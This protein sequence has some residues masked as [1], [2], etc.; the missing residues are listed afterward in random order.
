[1]RKKSRIQSIVY[2]VMVAVCLSGC[3]QTVV[4]EEPVIKVDISEEEADYRMEE[5]T[6]GD[7]ILTKNIS[8]NYVQTKAQEIAFTK[9]GQIID[10]VYVK[11]GDKVAVGDL[12]VELQNGNLEDEI[13]DLEYAIRRT[14]LQYGYLDVYEKFDLDSAYYTFVSST[15]MEEEDLEEYEKEKIEIQDGYKERREDFEDTLY[16]DRLKL[17]QKKAELSSNRI[18]ATMDGT[19]ISMEKDLEGST[20]KRDQVI[21]LVVDNSNGLFET[22]DEE[23]AAFIEEDTVLPMVIVYGTA[24]G[25]YEVVPYKKETWGEKQ[26]F[27]AISEPEGATLEVGTA[28]TITAVVDQKENVLCISKQALY[29]ADGKYYVYMPDEAGLKQVRFIE[30]GLI[31]DTYVEVV[32]GITEGEKVIRK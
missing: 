24:K 10:K 3:G 16:F 18:Y 11:E 15:D 17:E 25:D 27:Q 5:V 2:M 12:L 1:M 9:G 8:S 29:Q 31:G 28:G 6:R 7:V 14:E 30:I 4:E 22:E 23:I 32:S 19:V 26:M 21:M 20:A 13:A